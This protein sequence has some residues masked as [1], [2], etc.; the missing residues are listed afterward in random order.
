[1]Y[2]W[3]A[4]TGYWGGVKP[5]GADTDHYNSTLKYSASTP[6]SLAYMPEIDSL[7]VQGLGLVN[8]KSVFQF[9]DELHNYLA[10]SGVDGV[11]V[12]VQ[13]VLETVGSGFGGRVALTSQYQQA[14]EA[15]IAQNFPDN[16]CIACMSHGTDALYL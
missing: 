7:S 11:K 1:M 9:Y 12:D 2:V 10:A 14:L 8:P 5:G 13:S 3:H 6:D 15:S 4:I 16:G